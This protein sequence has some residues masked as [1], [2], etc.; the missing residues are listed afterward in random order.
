MADQ[1][2]DVVI[3]GGGHNGLVCAFYLARAGLKVTVLER[4]GVVGGAAVTETFHP[5]FRNSTASYTVSLLNPRVI[6]DMALDRHGLTIVERRMAN[7]LPQEDGRYLAAGQGRTQAEVAKFSSRDADRLPAYEARLETVAAVLRA[8]VLETPPNL[9][10]GGWR[11]GLPEMLKAAG[12]ARRLGGLDLTARRDV[13]D[14][15]NK[16]AGDWLDGWFESDPVKAL[17]G[18]DSV[19]GNYA[20]PYTPGSA[21]VLLHHV[22]GE[23]N[24]IKGAWGHAIGGMGAITQAMAAACAEQ[25]VEVRLD[26]PVSEVLTERGRAVGAVTEAGDVVRARAVVSNLHP[27]LLFDRLVDPAVVPVDFR[28]RMAGYRSGSGTFRMNVALSELPRFSAHP[29]AGDHHTAGV[30][31]AP[32]LSYMD[33]AHAEA[34]LTGWS[35]RPIIEM[36]IP[37]TL[38]DS[39]APAGAHV[40]S[41]FCQHVAPQL[42]DGR[43]WDDHR[44]TVADL[45]IDTV[46][47]WAPG[48]KASVLGRLAL[49]PLDLERRF[50]LVGGDIFHGRLT[51]D[52]LF[53][54]RPVLGHAD[55]RMPVPG[56]YLCG[57]GAHPGGGVTGAPGHNAAKEILKDFRR[58]RRPAP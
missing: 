6:A 18:F 13:L 4:R 27:R 2:R 12:L 14:L 30:I 49:T 15:F 35:G 21:Y 3:L 46:D 55:H 43:S 37:S 36:L 31:L 40:A 1:D 9:T 16:S 25:G 52:Q 8:M 28:E 32:S 42:S 53:S 33:R 54:A 45:M 34:R 24:G 47:R 58:W 56:L 22:F 50:G 11:D 44:D 51:L 48:F 10:D 19:V 26:S 29:S 23:V 20:S 41:L 5:G 39:L 57:S 17:F 38:D 7:F